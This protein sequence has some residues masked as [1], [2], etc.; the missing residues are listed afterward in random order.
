VKVGGDAES[1]V[2][3]TVRVVVVV[4]V[5]ISR[6]KDKKSV[7]ILSTTPVLSSHTPAWRKILPG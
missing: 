4:L 3:V 1:G 2:V 5:S 7:L 6:P